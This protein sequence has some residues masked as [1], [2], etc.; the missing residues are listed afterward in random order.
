[1]GRRRGLS[2][3]APAGGKNRMARTLMMSALGAAALA[4]VSLEARAAPA[5]YP[6]EALADYV[7]GC[8]ATNGQSQ[9]ALRRCSCSI[10]A[11]AEKVPYEDYVRA[12]TV[13]RMQQVEGGG[14]TVMFRTSPWAQAMIDKL[15]QAQVEAEFRCF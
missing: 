7:F 1:M 2:R 15:R 12:E 5:D 13:L 9:E 14:R 10:D 4:S 3:A 8:M 11:I 6:T